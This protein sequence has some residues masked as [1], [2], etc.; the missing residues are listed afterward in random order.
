MGFG[1]F[2]AVGCLLAR[3]IGPASSRWH[4]Q[5]GFCCSIFFQALEQ[6]WEA[7][8][9]A[10]LEPW[11]ANPRDAPSEALPALC[12]LVDGAEGTG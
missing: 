10:A 4:L 12:M 9:E 5:P 11:G 7:I 3:G 2:G 6:A 8:P 1:G